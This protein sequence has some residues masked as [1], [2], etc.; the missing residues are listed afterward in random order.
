MQDPQPKT[1]RRPLTR[2][3]VLAAA[4]AIADRDGLAGVTMRTVGDSIGV[5]AMAL[6]RHVRNKDD[7]LDGL[8]AAVVEEVNRACDD[9]SPVTDASQ[10]RDA[11]RR[12]IL[13]ARSVMLQHPWAP[14]LISARGTFDL[15]LMEYFDQLGGT[16]VAGGCSIDLVHRAMHALGSRALGFSPE[17]FEPGAAAQQDSDVS[18]ELIEQFARRFPVIARVATELA[19][20]A[21]STVGWCDDQAEF[22]FGLDLIL[23]GLE[24]RRLQEAS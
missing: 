14:A 23:D 18:L 9:L 24:A 16:L 2:E 7:L 4:M 15:S 12:R 13:T 5:E 8:V 19:H 10:W 17:L 11:A 6:Y 22:E 20:D 3:R 1:R 21:D